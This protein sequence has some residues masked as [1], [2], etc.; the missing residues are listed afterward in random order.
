VTTPNGIFPRGSAKKTA[1]FATSYRFST[2]KLKGLAFGVAGSY[3]GAFNVET[4]AITDRLARYYL[5]GYRSANGFIS[6]TWQQYRFQ[7]NVTNLTDEWYL[8]RSVSKD[9]ILQGPVRSFRFRV[10][11]TF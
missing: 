3:K 5:P 2:G 1:N 8:L 4:P 11:K 6:Y 10:A 9:Q 7:L